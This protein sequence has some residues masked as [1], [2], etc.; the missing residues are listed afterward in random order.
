MSLIEEI[1]VSLTI[2]E[3]SFEF[4]QV[5]FTKNA[6]R[7]EDQKEGSEIKKCQCDLS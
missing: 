7:P 1:M 4:L 6:A 2:D 5:N 3:V